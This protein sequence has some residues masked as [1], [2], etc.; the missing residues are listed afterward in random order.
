MTP[1]TTARPVTAACGTRRQI[2]A[3]LA[4]GPLGIS[5][6]AGL[7]GC[8]RNSGGE[9]IAANNDTNIKRLG[10]LYGLFHL[11]NG[12]RGPRDEA[13]FKAFIAA[14][15]P[16]RLALAGIRPASLDTLFVSE[17]DRLPFRIRYG[18]DTRVRGP[19]LAVAFEQVGRE[20][21]REVGFTGGAVQQADASAYDV[22]WAE[23]ADG[24]PGPGPARD[25]GF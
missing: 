12:L 24:S 9:M 18:L 5:L 8:G 17:R 13:E 23:A 7:P 21:L 10:T 14:Q 15:D 20:G 3:A 16:A 25:R 6:G 19:A 22:L 2:L 1:H 4:Y 11:R